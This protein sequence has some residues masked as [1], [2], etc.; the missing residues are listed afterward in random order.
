MDDLNAL[1]RAEIQRRCKELN[2]PATGNTAKLVERIRN[3]TNGSDGVDV[4]S[5]GNSTLTNLNAFCLDMVN[6]GF[7]I[8]CSYARACWLYHYAFN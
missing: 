4:G 7:F 3:K 6:H 2:L 5:N 8:N 1:S